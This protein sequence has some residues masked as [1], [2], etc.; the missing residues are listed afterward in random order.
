MG[1]SPIG[2]LAAGRRLMSRR[3]V[4]LGAAASLL[5]AG[6]GEA[7]AGSATPAATGPPAS[8]PFRISYGPDESH[9][10][11]L[12]LPANFEPSHPVVVTIHGGG[13]ET[14]STLDT[15]APYAAE[16]MER[17]V[18]VWN[19]EYRLVGNGGGWP[20]TFQDVAAAVDALAGPVQQAAGGRLDLARV[21]V[22]GYSA[23][24]HLAVWTAGRGHL[25]AGAP[26]AEPAVLVT[27]MVGLAPVLDLEYAADND[28]TTNVVDLMGATPAEDPSRFAIASPIR[29][30]PVG[31]PV[32]CVHGDDDTTVP[33]IQGQ[34]YA[35]TARAQG[36][37]VQ[38]V[39]LPGL[40][41]ESIVDINGKGWQIARDA[42]LQGI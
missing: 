42:V 18:A 23:G 16:L 24:G 38:L 7:A 37:V 34:Q 5:T 35:T 26:G 30:L 27:A 29:L 19:I 36:D 17:G 41:H 6:C 28:A 3:A 2:Q 25:P 9:C 21:R 1:P 4:L 8:G 11:D 14:G 10:G 13:W 22:L 15:F 32:T 20:M 40:D 12:L 39:E 33:R 31:V